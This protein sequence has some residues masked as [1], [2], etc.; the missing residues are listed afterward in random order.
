MIKTLD[1]VGKFKQWF[2]KNVQTIIGIDV[3]TAN[4]LI[5]LPDKGIVLNEA[6]TIA[7]T[8]INGENSNY[9]YGNDAKELIGKT[10]F[11]INVSHPID[12]GIIQNHILSEQML[13]KFISKTI[14]ENMLFQ[15]VIVAG[16][17]FSATEAEKKIL[18]EV[19][20]RCNAKEVYMIYESVASAIGANLPVEQP[21]GS[22]IIDIGGG[23]TEMSV[24]SL[25]GIIK[26]RTFKYGGYKLDK[27][28][29]DFIEHKYQ[30]LIG[31]N[32]SEN[33]KK[34]LAT[35]YLPPNEE[36][37]K[38]LVYGRNLKTNAPEEIT[39]SQ[40]DIVMAFAE[41]TNQFIENLNTLL[42]MTPPELMRDIIKNG[43]FICGGGA[44]IGNLDYVIKQITGLSTTICAE[45]ELCLTHGLEKIITNIK[46]YR[47]LLFQQF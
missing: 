28:I 39:V 29:V 43:I 5:C 37:K 27:S 11:K 9:V 23:T 25:G 33:I 21:I 4:T 6:S 15:P 30:L 13:R 7:Y 12:E 2:K 18:Q 35:V 3:G 32:T 19:L 8:N 46:P 34:Q 38:M 26:N 16:I 40:E 36:N 44:H 41:F 14:G 31:E 17:P 22:L 1:F 20:E 10:P 24:I 42:E 45:P 47:H